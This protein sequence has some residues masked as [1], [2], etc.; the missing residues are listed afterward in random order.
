MFIFYALLAVRRI[1]MFGCKCWRTLAVCVSSCRRWKKSVVLVRFLSFASVS[2]FIIILAKFN[3]ICDIRCV[4][5][6]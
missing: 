6:C 5:C 4:F 3:V 2:G 1:S